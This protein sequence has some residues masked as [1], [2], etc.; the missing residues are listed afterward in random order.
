MKVNIKKKNYVFFLFLL[1][2]VF[3]LMS[4]KATG[5]KP[6]IAKN[7]KE[8]FNSL[9]P[10]G[11]LGQELTLTEDGKS[12]YIILTSNRPTKEDAKAAEDLREW[13]RQMTGAKLSIERESGDIKDK[14]KF[15]SI[16]HTKLLNKSGLNSIGEDLKDEGYRIDEKGERLFLWGGRTRGVIN[17]VYALLEE[18]LGCRWY[19]NECTVIPRW[20][21]LKFTPVL[22]TY[23]PA[24]KI[25]DPFWYV[26]FDSIWSLR[27][28]TNAP[29]AKVPE[30]WG[31]TVD[32]DGMFVHTFAKL[33]PEKEYFEKHPEYYMLDG[34]NTRN[35]HQLCTTNPVVIRI[36]EEKVRKILKENP[37]TEI[38]SVSKNDGGGTCQ[39]TRC[40]SIDDA[41]GSKMASLLVLVNTV[42]RNIAK[43]YPNVLISTLA[44]GETSKVPKNMRPEQN[45]AIRLCSDKSG[46]WWHPFEPSE[47]CEIGTL[48][49]NW[50]A[51]CKR[52]YIWDYDINFSH[53]LAPMPN[54]DIIAQNIRFYVDHNT[55]GIMLQGNYQSPGSERDWMRSWVAAKLLWEPSRNLSDLMEDF[56]Y[57]YF[58]KAAPPIAEYNRLLHKQ[59]EIYKTELSGDWLMEHKYKPIRYG[60]DHPFL[61][62]EFLYYATQLYNNA[63]ELA[64]NQQVLD[65]VQRDRLPITYVKL[66]KGPEYVGDDYGK[67]MERFEKTVKQV[68]LTH[69]REGG[70]S[71]DLNSKIEKWREEWKDYK[72]IKE[73]KPTK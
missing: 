58:G 67:E 61:S 68:G 63:E 16:G 64:D 20:Q 26:A 27:N 12:D 18:D 62:K 56:I 73:N 69:F 42:A 31:G 11:K 39:C 66:M 40:K 70:S 57:G 36:V 3:G 46:A 29:S 50:S 59:K 34:Q 55:E 48:V 5:I 33:L 72:L 53:Y 9:K 13:L 21:T 14:R 37:H 10:K 38:I 25:R 24:L 41:E 71:E 51:V 22:R 54:M 30:E 49:K 47:A 15:I 60:M 35:P 2:I 7:S 1:L 65:R 43:D 52:L 45:V 19:S 4:T 6:G 8:W 28:R 32:Y 44:Y 17:A 23:R